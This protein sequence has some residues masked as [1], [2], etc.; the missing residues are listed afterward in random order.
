MGKIRILPD[1]VANQIAAGEVVERPVAVVKELV[2]NALDAGATRID[3]AFRRGGKSLIRVTDNGHG[4]SPDDAHL[5]LERH[6]TSKI[7]QAGDLE[8][9]LSFGFRGEALPS[10]A[11]VSRFSLSTRTS[12]ALTGVEIQVNG[13]KHLQTRECGMNPGTSIEVTQLFNSVPARRKFLKT[14]K[15]EAAHIIELCRLLAVAHP[16]VH[17]SLEEDGRRVFESP[18]CP[19]LHERVAEIFG[20][21]LAS[22]LLAIEGGDPSV[23]I[24]LRVEEETSRQKSADH[25]PVPN[26]GIR[27]YGLIMKPGLGR[28]TRHDLR[29]YVNRRPVDARLLNFAVIEA[30]H[31]FLPKNRYPACFLFLDVPPDTVDVNVHPAKREIRFRQEARIRRLVME[32]IIDK[33]QTATRQGRL[34]ALNHGPLPQPEQGQEKTAQ[35]PRA[36]A[37]PGKP[38]ETIPAAKP[39]VA[40]SPDRPAEGQSTHGKA[41][42]PDAPMAAAHRAPPVSSPTGITPTRAAMSKAAELLA[43]RTTTQPANRP[44]APQHPVGSVNKTIPEP[45]ADPVQSREVPTAAS[46]PAKNRS[47]WNFIGLAHGR[48]ALFQSQSGIVCLHLPSA[49]ARILYENFLDAARGGR[50]PRQQ[51][52][53]PITFDLDPLNAA[54]L[55]EHTSFFENNGFGI[56]PFGGTTFRLGSLPEW[57]AMEQAESFVRDMSARI[58]ERGLRPDKEA[59]REELACQASLR[60]AKHAPTPS[61]ATMQTIVKQ[62]LTCRNPLNDPLGRPTYF[63]IPNT[64]L[65][66]RLAI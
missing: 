63:E 34:E 64:E 40:G 48:Y 13:G 52:L 59:T 62:L 11:S 25:A 22:E 46:S 14:D 8:K 43:R 56:E 61:E 58:R 32:A 51:L 27:L 30:Y 36:A 28:A 57:F 45:T 53:F 24:P 49:R 65:E 9:I 55:L 16:E 60:A 10:I 50:I 6:A 29:T 12:D 26:Q 37:E 15:T 2:E 47:P 38:S 18:R 35:S 54:T 33:L 4:M 5:A 19:S 20:R 23:A 7:R 3:V 39:A 1:V 41:L 31:T 66:R 42:P 17:F 44:Q 21:R